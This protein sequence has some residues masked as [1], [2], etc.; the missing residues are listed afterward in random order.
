MCVFG[1]E[2]VAVVQLTSSSVDAFN[3]VEGNWNCWDTW[4][5]GAEGGGWLYTPPN[6]FQ[7]LWAALI[8]SHVRF[9]RMRLIKT[10]WN[11]HRLFSSLL[12]ASFIHHVLFFRSAVAQTELA[13]GPGLYDTPSPGCECKLLTVAAAPRVSQVLQG[14]RGHI[15]W[16]HR[17]S[18]GREGLKN[19]NS[20]L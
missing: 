4:V 7:P 14:S 12:P 17:H 13:R 16:Y 20:N 1:C 11:L 2:N 3:E 19:T 10:S 15:I 5:G 18:G 6:D 9:Y 8:L